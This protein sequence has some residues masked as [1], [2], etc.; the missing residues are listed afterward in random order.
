MALEKATRPIAMKSTIRGHFFSR[1]CVDCESFMPITFV[2]GPR[3]VCLNNLLTT[4]DPSALLYSQN[5]DI[6]TVVAIKFGEIRGFFA[7]EW[8]GLGLGILVLGL[9]SWVL[10]LWV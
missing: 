1:I 5:T 4:L 8:S 2:T 10:G 6:W 9:W 7:V 3:A